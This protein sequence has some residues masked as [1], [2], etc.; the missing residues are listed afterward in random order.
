MISAVT[1]QKQLKAIGASF[2]FFGKAEIDELPKIMVEGEE[3]QHII[4]GRYEGG[5]ATLCATNF[6]ILLVDKKILFLTVE[7]VRYDM[8]AEL[9]YGHQFWGATIHIRSFS[10]D[11]KFQ[12]YSKEKLRNFTNFIQQRV[13][14]LRQHHLQPQM[15][16]AVTAMP[17]PVQTF[18]EP[19]NQLTPDQAASLVP[20]TREKWHKAN[21]IPK[22]V[23]PYVQSP[24]LTRKRVGRY[25]PS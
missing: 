8:I 10:K 21:P 11:L 6:R 15:T 5:Y 24:L 14:E 22:A 4:T 2:P 19:D 17:I 9:D 25:N 12:C 1:V 3:I 16:D 13:M 18:N 23:N 20:I 7:D